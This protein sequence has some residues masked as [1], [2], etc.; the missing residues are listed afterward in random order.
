M[1]TVPTLAATE[2]ALQAW[3]LHGAPAIEAAVIGDARADARTRL[4]VY[5]DA[6]RLRLLEVLRNDYPVL[7]ARLGL[8]AF[9][10]RGRSYIAA[11]PSDTPSVRWF[12]RHLSEHLRATEPERA[13]LSELAAFE[14]AQGEVFDAPDERLAMME[15]V[16]AIPAAAWPGMRLLLHPAVRRLR[17]RSNAPALASAHGGG[18]EL[19]ATAIEDSA[20]DWLLWRQDLNIH[21]RPLSPDEAGAFDVV[22]GGGG[23]GQICERLCQW[24]APEDVAMHAASLLK[25]W[26]S[27]GLLTQIEWHAGADC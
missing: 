16:G 15:E 26:L 20:Q 12:G 5:A 14:W 25:R 17:L 22:Q 18:R 3:V 4:Q 11:H 13:E 8:E 2:D 1:K 27:E 24:L 6:Y 23:F 9:E 10:Q 19:P 21:W 7:L